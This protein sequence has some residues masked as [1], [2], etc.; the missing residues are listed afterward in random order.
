MALHFVLDGY[1]IIKQISFLAEGKLES[2]REKLI[3][4]IEVKS[5]Q[6][7]LRN[8]VTIIFDGQ[9]VG[10]GYQRSS[11]IHIVFS[12]QEGA[13]EK[14]KRLVT[15]EKNKKCIV[16]VTDDRD[17]QYYVRSQ[18]A[19]VLGVHHFLNKGSDRQK[20][21]LG[22]PKASL[23]GEVKNLSKNLEYEITSELERIWLEKKARHK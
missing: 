20:R 5:P 13:D 16:V 8:K 14:I 10:G 4:F 1:N 11:R 6:G 9:S 12:S 17:I 19:Q 2:Q 7:S 18:G 23:S 22:D 21:L 15:Q 3:R